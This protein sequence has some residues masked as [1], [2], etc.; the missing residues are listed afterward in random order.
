MHVPFSLYVFVRLYVWEAYCRIG[1]LVWTG[2]YRLMLTC[3]DRR[4]RKLLTSHYLY[5]SLRQ[6]DCFEKCDMLFFTYSYA[7]S[8]IHL[9][10]RRAAL[11]ESQVVMATVT[12]VQH[13]ETSLASIVSGL[14][15]F[16]HA[17]EL[18]VE[19]R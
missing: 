1:S 19:P 10:L 16:R 13:R 14:D 6:F 7:I 15:V 8:R 3:H 12:S 18:F 9:L 17:R 2:R 11:R 4:I 5:C